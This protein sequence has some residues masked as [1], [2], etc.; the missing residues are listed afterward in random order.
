MKKNI[1][2]EKAF[3]P[4]YLA[5]VHIGFY[6]D[7]KIFEGILVSLGNE[8][9]S[10]DDKNKMSD[11]MERRMRACEVCPIHILAVWDE[12]EI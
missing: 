7:A 10:M 5:S 11:S 9:L 4:S 12:E 2:E 3:S 8:P 6:E 1:Q